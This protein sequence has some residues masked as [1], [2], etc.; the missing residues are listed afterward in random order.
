MRKMCLALGILLVSTVAF[1]QQDPMGENYDSITLEVATGP[2]GTSESAGCSPVAEVAGF[3]EMGKVLFLAAEK[4]ADRCSCSADADCG[5]YS[6]L[7][8]SDS[9]NPCSCTSQD[10][11]CSAGRRGFVRCN[12]STTYC[13]PVCGGALVCDQTCSGRPCSSSS[14]CGN[15]NCPQGFCAPAGICMCVQ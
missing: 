13:G 1:A 6:D 7:W 15:G 4:E 2:F 12:G 9:T 14:Q 8:C 5:S 10:R 3:E 11:N